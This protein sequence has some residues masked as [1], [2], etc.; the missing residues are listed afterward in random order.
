[1]KPASYPMVIVG[2]PNS[3]VS[4]VCWSFSY[5]IPG[6][7]SRRTMPEQC[8]QLDTGIEVESNGS[9]EPNKSEIGHIPQCEMSM[10]DMTH[11]Y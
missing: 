9:I 3:T 8:L 7:S 11:F 2:I 6:N 5:T 10:K 1:M 4:L